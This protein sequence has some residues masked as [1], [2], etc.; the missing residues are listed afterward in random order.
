MQTLSTSAETGDIT[1]TTEVKVDVPAG[2]DVPQFDASAEHQLKEA[3]KLVQDLAKNHVLA[4][5]ADGTHI[6]EPH[7]STSTKKRAHEVDE[8][9]EP[10]P[11]HGT[12][13]DALGT[14]DNRSFFAKL[15]RRNPKKRRTPVQGGRETRALPASRTST[16]AN[17]DVPQVV[18]REEDNLEE[19]RR[20]VAGL[21]LAVAVGA[22]AAAP[23]LFG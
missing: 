11:E 8:D 18:I 5:L 21:G 10:L 15:F 7:A 23:Y 12:L 20:W 13:A 6:P 9:D 16:S 14:V 3:Q 22:T 2:D 19:G 1:E 17:A 4:D